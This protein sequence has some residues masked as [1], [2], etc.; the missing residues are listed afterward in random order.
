M[1]YFDMDGVLADFEGFFHDNNIKFDFENHEKEC[2]QVVSDTPNFYAKLKPIENA[3]ELFKYCKEKYGAE[4]LSAVP[5]PFRNVPTAA[6]DKREWLRYHID[7]KT[8]QEAHLCYRAEK[9]NFCKNPDD[10]LID[11]YEINIR[12]WDKKGGMGILFTNIEDV[13][14]KLDEIMAKN[15]ISNYDKMKNKYEK[16]NNNILKED[17]EYEG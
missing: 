13:K 8:A 10:I 15:K 6:D 2:W 17:L 11:D 9:E 16:S 1:I 3:I 14:K 7:E 5:K 4:I 12:E